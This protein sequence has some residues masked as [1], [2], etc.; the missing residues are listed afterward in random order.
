[1]STTIRITKLRARLLSIRDPETGD[2]M[3]AYKVASLIGIPPSSLSD[4]AGAR[5]PYGYKHLVKICQ[6]FECEPH[7]ITGD[8][9]ITFPDD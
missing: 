2:I 3:R 5:R 1:M 7:Q 8:V 6:F 9:E 4:Y